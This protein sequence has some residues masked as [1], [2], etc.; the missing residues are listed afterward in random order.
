MTSKPQLLFLILMPLLAFHF[1]SGY[2]QNE[3]TEIRFEQEAGSKRSKY[4]L[5]GTIIQYETSEPLEGVS[6]HIDGIFGGN[7]TD[8]K[9]QYSISLDSGKH[10]IVFRQFG[11]RPARYIVF[12]YGDGQLD[13]ALTDQDFELEVFTVQA[14]ERDRNIRGAITGVTKMNID[15]IKLVPAFLG[16]SDVFNVL[17]SMPGVN[18]VG[19]GSAG[20]NIRGG[21]ADQNL[22]MMNEA[23]VLSNSHAL[24][25]LSSFNGDVLQNFTLFKGTVPSYFGGRSASAL[26]IEMRKGSRENWKGNVSLGTS[27]S[28]F[29]IEGPIVPEKTSLIFASRLSNT[30]WILNKVNEV[31]VKNSKINFHDLYLGINHQFSENN[32]LDFNLLTTGDYFRFSN[33]FGFE[34]DNLVG[35][36]TSRNLLTDNF[37]L[38]G[39]AA[40]GSFNNSFFEPSQI[41][42]SK[43]ENGLYY[44]Q[45]KITGFL[46]LEK[47]DINFGA[48][49]IQYK[50]RPESLSPLTEESGI[51]AETNQKERGLEFAPFV[52]AEWNPSENFSV[53]GGIRY[54]NYIQQGP[55][56]VFRY[57]EG[58]P[59][60]RLTIDGVHFIESGQVVKYNGLEPRLSFRW[61]LGNSSSI[62]GGYSVLNQYLQTISNATG[63][64]P[65]DLW[66]LSTTYILPQRSYNV[67]LGY[68][69]NFKED[70]WSTSLEGFY[71][72]TDNQLEYR[73]F[74]DLFVNPHLETELIQGE[75]RAYGAEVLIQKNSGGITG[76]LAYTYTRSLIRTTSEF[77]QIQVNQGN[78]F[79]TNFD[80]PH[81]VSLV[82]NIHFRKGKTFNMNFNFSSG[83]PVTGL[84]SN[85]VVGG[86]FVPNFGNRNEFRIPNYFRIDFSYLTNGFVRKWD[87]KINFSVYNLTGRRNAYSVFFQREG[88]SQR[89]IPFQVSILGS[90]FPSFTY[91]VSFGK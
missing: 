38:I 8:S 87:D 66:Q 61:T 55:D 76:W 30:N 41:D 20:M 70:M 39:M 68:F 60:S 36:L 15:E 22:I 63:P 18:S 37:S 56:S 52:S 58:V 57:Q 75:G 49:A 54:S 47:V 26:N 67:S 44:Y 88:R 53:S 59:R 81:T 80:K 6:I 13:L 85:Y 86:V 82:T 10:R 51:E 11:K 19:E 46:T 43:I 29:L 32:S 62:K 89:L 35:S 71:R 7:N 79:A 90:V 50:M 74:A 31:D 14:E 21:Q 27:I 34:W 77:P 45:G 12:L 42:P 73:D 3:F 69:R 25:F 24:G 17:Q 78:W 16:E 72:T 84:T 23:I 5:K 64:T 40:F 9:G 2:A 28:K 33:Q 48:E 91:T 1:Q 4:L 65:I 83:R